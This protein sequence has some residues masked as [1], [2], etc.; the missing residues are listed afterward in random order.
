[1]RYQLEQ[2]Q[3]N[4]IMEKILFTIQDQ[5]VIVSWV[6]IVIKVKIGNNSVVLTKVNT[7]SQPDP[8]PTPVAPTPTPEKPNQLAFRWASVNVQGEG[9]REVLQVKNIL[10][11]TNAN[12]DSLIRLISGQP[13]MD[14]QETMV[15]IL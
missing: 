7:T 3:D 6:N 15:L 13:F 10:K 12:F 1:M 14:L 2:L 5:T 9:T 11:P 4:T 8:T